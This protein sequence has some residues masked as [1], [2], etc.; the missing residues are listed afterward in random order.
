MSGPAQPLEARLYTAARF[1]GDSTL[2]VAWWCFGPLP[3]VA[4]DVLNIGA[5]CLQWSGVIR[6][7]FL[8]GDF[9]ESPIT[10]PVLQARVSPS[11]L[12]TILSA[13]QEKLF[14]G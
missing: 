8:S 14:Q 12:S 4:C 1:P 2:P 10:E 6:Q 3:S 11:L 9:V 13:L 5:L 7:D